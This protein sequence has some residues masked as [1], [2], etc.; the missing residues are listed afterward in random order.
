MVRAH[1]CNCS[2]CNQNEILDHNMLIDVPQDM[3]VPHACVTHT[4]HITCTIHENT[5]DH[6]WIESP[7]NNTVVSPLTH[8]NGG[9]RF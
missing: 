9:S 8:N 4:M 3:L 1:M 7:K 6:L 5:A 2:P